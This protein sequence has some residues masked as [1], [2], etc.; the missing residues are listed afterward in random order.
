MDFNHVLL[1]DAEAVSMSTFLYSPCSLASIEMF[2][3]ILCCDM[4][5]FTYRQTTGSLDNLDQ[6]SSEPCIAEFSPQNVARRS[7]GLKGLIRRSLLF[8][9]QSHAK[10]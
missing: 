5:A 9:A 1:V 6:P 8:Q 4:Q 2:S 3:V 7:S 10:L